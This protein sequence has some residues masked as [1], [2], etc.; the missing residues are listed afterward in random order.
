MPPRLITLAIIAFWLTMTGFLIHYEVMP[1]MLAEVSPHF[2]PDLTDEISSPLVG[3][4]VLRDGN[5][6]G[7]GTSKVIANDDGQ[8]EFRSSFHFEKLSIGN[9]AHIRSL[10]NVYRVTEDGTSCSRSRPRLPSTS[11]RNARISGPP[12]SP[13]ASTAKSRT[14]SSSRSFPS[15]ARN[16]RSTRSTCRSKEASSIRCTSSIASRPAAPGQEDV[17]NQSDRPIPRP[18]R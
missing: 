10:E 2:Q 14:A 9:S 13:S 11:A 3:W 4:T 5:R 15:T 8:F 16:R 17:E 6:I 7:S 12:I 1:M 18:D